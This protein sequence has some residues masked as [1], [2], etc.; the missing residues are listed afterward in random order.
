M[1]LREARKAKGYTQTELSEM[2]GVSQQQIAKYETGQSCPANKV[3]AK[4]AKALDQTP[5]DVWQ[6]IFSTALSGGDEK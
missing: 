5:G 6:M 1:T 2:V 4:I 3:I